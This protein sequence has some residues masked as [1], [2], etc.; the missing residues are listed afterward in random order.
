MSIPT[1]RPRPIITLQ[2]QGGVHPERYLDG[3]VG[4]LYRRPKGVLLSRFSGYVFDVTENTE[5]EPL[6]YL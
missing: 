5:L 6:M 4:V 2:S 3:L 1:V